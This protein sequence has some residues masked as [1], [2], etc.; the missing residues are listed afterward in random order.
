MLQL[1]CFM[2][3]LVVFVP[4]YI[5]LRSNIAFSKRKG[6]MTVTKSPFLCIA[7]YPTESKVRAIVEH[8]RTQMPNS[9]I[10]CIADNI[11]EQPLWMQEQSVYFVH[12]RAS[13]KQVLSCANIRKAKNLLVLSSD[14]TDITSDEYTFSIVMVAVTMQSNLYVVVEKVRQDDSLFSGTLCDKVVSVSRACELSHELLYRGAL[15]IVDALFT[16]A[17]SQMQDNAVLPL[18]LDWR[19]V[20]SYYADRS[21]I[22]LGYRLEGQ[23]TFQFCPDKRVVLPK[24]TII[25]IV[26]SSE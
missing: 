1:Q 20:M 21:Q 22:A 7:G 3:C 25:K 12:G 19:G 23:N 5:K 16:P 4:L 2:L 6:L 26:K 24:G 14:P 18:D 11:Q 10:V 9:V 15:D 17:S 8:V 13:D